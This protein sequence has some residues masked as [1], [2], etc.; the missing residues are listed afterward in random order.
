[1]AC[2]SPYSESDHSGGGAGGLNPDPAEG[3]PLTPQEVGSETPP[4]AA[5]HGHPVHGHGQ[6]PDHGHSQPQRKP[7]RPAKHAAHAPLHQFVRQLLEWRLEQAQ[8]QWRRCAR[9]A[10]PDEIHDLRVS[11][12]RF[13]ENLWLFRR[14]FPK[15]ERRQVR[16]ELKLVMR[17][18]GACRDADIAIESFEK[19]GVLPGPVYRLALA[20]A[21]ATAEAALVAALAA[22]LKTDFAHRWRETL[23]LAAGDD[24]K[25]D[26][27][28]GGKGE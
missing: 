9:K 2:R 13:G 6:T 11:L 17:L 24:H 5:G 22:G 20:N 19:A 25:P 1:M 23:R 4:L 3:H 21:R 18:T 12:R 14:L 15:R 7:R 26:A 27:H 8:K 28:A 16:G 10:G